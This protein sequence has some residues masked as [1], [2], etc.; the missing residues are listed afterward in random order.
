MATAR[1]HTDSQVRETVERMLADVQRRGDA[2]MRKL[3]RRFDASDRESYRL[4]AGGRSRSAVDPW[5]GGMWPT[6]SLRRRRC[7]TSRE[8]SEAG[9][10]GYG[11]GLRHREGPECAGGLLCG[12]TM[13][14]GMVTAGK[15]GFLIQG[16]VQD[17]MGAW[18]F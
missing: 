9:R 18:C 17:L 4:S 6:S 10:G 14:R 12:A 5:P 8:S 1:Q 7:G 13:A 16:T 2:A 3:N 15:R 11:G